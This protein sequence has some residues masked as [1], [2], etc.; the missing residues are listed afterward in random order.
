MCLGLR[1]FRFVL[2]M[3]RGFGSRDTPFSTPA[4]NDS[5]PDFFV[6]NRGSLIPFRMASELDVQGSPVLEKEFS[7]AL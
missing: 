2:F 1:A 7:V 3:A 5:Q 4:Q 6:S